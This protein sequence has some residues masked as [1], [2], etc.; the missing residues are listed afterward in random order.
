MGGGARILGFGGVVKN[1]D[2]KSGMGE[3]ITRWWG[4]AALA[5][6][7]AMLAAA[8]ASGAW[9]QAASQPAASQRAANAGGTTVE[10][11]IVT[12]E[13]RTESSLDVPMGLT[14]VSG[15]DLAKTESFRMEDFVGNIPA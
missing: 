13:K 12:A 11:L 7:T 6:G 5:G 8:C 4:R 2:W 9:A 1:A 15:S 3:K 14:T 10:A